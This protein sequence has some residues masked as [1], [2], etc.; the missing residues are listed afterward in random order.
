[1]TSPS[2][3]DQVYANARTRYAEWGVDTEAVL[4]A[5]QSF[6]LSLHCWQ[7]DDVR[8]FETVDAGASSGGIQVTGAYPG[9]A[10][11]IP[12]LQKDLE[13]AYSLIPGKHRLN[14]HAMYGDFGG[15]KIDRDRI[16]PDHFRVWMDWGREHDIALDF[17]STCFA[18]P[19]A[20][21][22][23]T[24][25][26]LDKGTRDFWIEHVRRCR[27]VSAVMGKLQGS[28]CIH[29]IWIPDGAKDI[30]VR[31]FAHRQTLRDALDT[32]F[33]RTYEP[34]EMIDAVESKLFG[35]GSESFVVGSHEFYLGYALTR[36]VMLCLDMGHFHPTESVADKV[37]ALLQYADGLLLHVSRG[38]RWDSDH[39][40]IF[41]DDVTAL[42]EEIVRAGAM[43][44]VHVAL[45]F[46]D[47]SVNR[48]GAWVLGARSTLKA[49]L[50]A[51][52]EP[53][54]KLE[55][56][57]ADGDFIGRLAVL[58]EM[59]SMPFGAVWEEYCVRAG[60][61]TGDGWLKNIREYEI[62]VLR[63]RG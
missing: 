18:H 20:D 31:R 61:A 4:S 43:K 23:Y 33:T 14:L 54:S 11:S 47:G 48:I 9:R 16:E 28:P 2:A 21:S 37:S 6:S 58:E 29:N 50:R 51:L 60:V 56:M 24:L 57:E 53:R 39:V 34:D 44:R 42:A 32:I 40:V 15:K 12:E 59:K 5:L 22:G 36:K 27:E 52:L 17:N 1:M 63:G 35:I 46:F 3:P 26:S 25:S 62:G 19:R 38:V 10:R 7:G 41:N 8:G 13:R 45:D 49:F 30:T 55:Q